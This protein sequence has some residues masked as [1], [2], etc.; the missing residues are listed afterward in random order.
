[1]DFAAEHRLYALFHLVAL[2]GLRRGEVFALRWRDVDLDAL[3]VL[4]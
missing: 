3:V 4:T 1:M 2:L